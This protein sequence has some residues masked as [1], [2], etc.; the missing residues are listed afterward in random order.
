L[1]IRGVRQCGKTYSLKEFGQ[2]NYRNVAYLNFED[3]LEL[4]SLFDQNLNPHRI[5]NDLNVIYGKDIDK[6]T[7][8]IFDEIQFCNHALTSLKYFYENAP[9]Y[10][11]IC[12]GSLLGIML[13]KPLSFPVGKVDIITMRPMSFREYLIARKGPGFCENIEGKTDAMP[14]VFLNELYR[15]Y[16]EY[17][18]VGGMPEVV[19][20]WL[21][22]KDLESVRK[23]QK[24]IVLSYEADFAK[25]APSNEVQKLNKIWNSIP[26]QLSK[27]NKKFVF[28]HAVTGARAKDLEDSLQWLIDAGLVHKVNMTERPSI[29]M[30]A[31]SDPSVF[32]LY[33][34]DIGLLGAMSGTPASSIIADD[35]RYK[36]FKGGMAENYVL[37]ELLDVTDEMP[38]YWRSG[39]K[40]EVDFVH[41]MCDE[42]VPIEVKSKNFSR[43]QS[44]ERYVT[45]YDPKKAFVI[46]ERNIKNGKVT[47]LP[48]SMV[49]NIISFVEKDLQS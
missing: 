36:E 3:E 30:S 45:Q 37:N 23:V 1:V 46:S 44:L 43:V 42:I 18:F 34:A 48:L 5:I 25:H 7:L 39:N 35:D 31:Y 8:I 29:P 12:A 13:S 2:K 47:F 24:T 32:K 40:A 17:C 22:T 33:Y 10:H 15:I 19:D 14:E 49:W 21:K 16:R 26:Q 41:M 9:E 38:Y 20:R 11:I 28:G 6:D 4:S 27:E